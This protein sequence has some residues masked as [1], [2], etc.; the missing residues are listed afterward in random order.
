MRPVLLAMVLSAPCAAAPA[1]LASLKFPGTKDFVRAA[2]DVVDVRLTLSPDTAA[3]AGLFEDAVRVPSFSTESVA[4]LD[5]RLQAD[6]AALRA[7]PWR[8][9][10]VDRQI[11]FRWTYAMAEEAHQQLAVER[12]YLHRPAAWLE[13]LAND[14]IALLT[15]APQR[16][17]LRA[18]L[19]CLI[20]GMVSE[21]RE[22]C[23]VPTQ[24]DVKT[25]DGVAAGVL[26]MLRAEP[27]S[28]T[29]DKALAYLDAYVKGLRE[30]RGLKEFEV[31]GAENY[32]WRFK[33][34]L[35]LPWTPAQLLELAQRELSRVDAEASLLK[36]RVAAPTATP[37]ELALARALTREAL[38]G[39]YDDVSRQDMEFLR[40]SN[41]LSVP[42]GVGPIRAR[43]TPDAMVPLT[44]DGGSMNPPPPF[45]D[46]NQGWWNVE[47]FR[48]DWPEPTR[49]AMVLDAKEHKRTGTGPYAVHEGVPGHHLQ[50]SIARLK[51]NPLRNLLQDNTFVEGWA[52]YAEEMFQEAG[53]LGTDPAARYNTLMSYRYRV[54]RV[55]YDTR[56][57]SGQWTLQQ[58]GDFKTEAA[59]GAGVVDEDIARAVNWPTQLIGY[60]AG[61]QQILALR[62]DCRRKLGARCTERRFHDELLSVGGVPLVFAR[63]KLLGEPVPGLE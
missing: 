62:A 1:A 47:H 19:A 30:L 59:P 4:A 13:P 43:E 21:M 37:E 39:L 40:R 29:R 50:L 5:A 34:H 52:L 17:D 58:A 15:Y 61:K 27:P 33:R 14:F 55:F 16:A 36:A 60:F 42:A 51:V 57:E 12:L 35:L 48:A 20:P 22:V 45:A 56:V 28:V 2:K 38:L 53:G 7:M 6:L 54:R 25:A 31:I 23:R 9:W 8:K 3:G 63:A 24:R 46:S 41:L 49:V 10:P 26:T 32:A 11:D 18:R 44:G